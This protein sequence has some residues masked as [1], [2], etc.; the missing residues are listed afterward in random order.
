MSVGISGFLGKLTQN[1]SFPSNYIELDS[2]DTNPNGRNKLLSWGL[3]MQR[4]IHTYMINLLKLINKRLLTINMLSYIEFFTC[5][6]T[7]ILI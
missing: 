6:K 2:K 5:N 7:V 4:K 1:T 3:N